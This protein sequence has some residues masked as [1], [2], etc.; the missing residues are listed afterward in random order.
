MPA[1]GIP[2]SAPA[3]F[4]KG[5]DTKNPDCW[6]K[7][8]TDRAPKEKRETTLHLLWGTAFVSVSGVRYAIDL[9][10]KGTVDEMDGS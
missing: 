4:R 10:L 2:K 6:V 9:I 5:E 3:K 8:Q 1:K 7:N